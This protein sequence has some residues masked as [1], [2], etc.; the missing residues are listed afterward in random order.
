MSPPNVGTPNPSPLVTLRDKVQRNELIVALMRPYGRIF[1]SPQLSSADLF[2]SCR[3]SEISVNGFD[4]TN[5]RKP[6]GFRSEICMDEMN[7]RP[8]LLS[9]VSDSILVCSQITLA[10]K[11][12][13]NIPFKY[14]T[15]FPAKMFPLT[16]ETTGLLKFLNSRISEVQ[17]LHFLQ[18]LWPWLCGRFLQRHHDLPGSK[19]PGA[20]VDV[21]GL[22]EFQGLHL[23]WPL[24]V[25]KTPICN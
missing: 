17:A 15:R 23:V 7:D 22:V 16:S 18:Q 13:F 14:F 1:P 9:L 6:H 4:G 8:F 3:T 2:C 21:H 11:H 19:G 20:A 25:S 10:R 12:V 5:C 24:A